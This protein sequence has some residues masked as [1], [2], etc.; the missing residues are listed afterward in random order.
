MPLEPLL[1]GLQE[2]TQT[3]AQVKQ[4]KYRLND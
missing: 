2:D 1:V 4:C 3:H